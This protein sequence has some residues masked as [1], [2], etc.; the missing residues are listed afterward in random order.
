M[1]STQARVGFAIGVGMLA[2][3]AVGGCDLAPGFS[4]DGRFVLFQSMIAKERGVLV[5]LELESGEMTTLVADHAQDGYGGY[6]AAF[7]KGDAEIFALAVKGG[8]DSKT[9]ALRLTAQGERLTKVELEDETGFAILP[10]AALG[11]FLL[12][13]GEAEEDEAEAALSRRGRAKN[14][15]AVTVVDMAKGVVVSQEP[16]PRAASIAGNREGF[17]YTRKRDTERE[18]VAVQV[19]RYRM[20][21]AGALIDEPLFEITGEGWPNVPDWLCAGK[22]HL[23]FGAHTKSWQRN[24]DRDSAEP[25]LFARITDFEG[26]TIVDLTHAGDKPDVGGSAFGHDDRSY[27]VANGDSLLRYSLPDGS[28]QILSLAKLG[29]PG[30]GEPI[31]MGITA[32]PV[33]PLVAIQLM[34]KEEEDPEIAY[35]LLVLDESKDGDEITV[36]ARVRAPRPETK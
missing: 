30:K 8:D 4:S 11:D 25:R 5:K 35:D 12:C 1:S 3:L 9:H 19:G 27:W 18:A 7:A 17:F 32:S 20:G 21:N 31:V 13:V 15:L 29:V 28:L 10:V 23:A 22:R 14:D 24:A 16:A 36:V 33:A 34:P 6:R 2:L 26:R